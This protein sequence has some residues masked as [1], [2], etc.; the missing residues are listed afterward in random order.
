M[1]LSA[2]LSRRTWSASPARAPGRESVSL[3]RVSGTDSASWKVLLIRTSHQTYPS[4]SLLLNKL[5]LCEPCKKSYHLTMLRRERDLAQATRLCF[6]EMPFFY[7]ILIVT[8]I[9]RVCLAA[10]PMTSWLSMLV[11]RSNQREPALFK[12][13][14]IQERRVGGPCTQHQSRG[15]REKK[16]ALVMTL[17][18]YLWPLRDIC[19]LPRKTVNPLSTPLSTSHSGTFR[20]LE[21]V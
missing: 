2:I 3:R 8:C 15:P 17:F 12:V 4:V 6:M 16:C 19:K 5:C 11:Y 14:Q 21:L 7:A 10:L 1:F 20:L 18:L 13:P 9:L